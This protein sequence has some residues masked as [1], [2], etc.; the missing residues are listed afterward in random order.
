MGLK[1]NLDIF[2]YGKTLNFSDAYTKIINV[3]GDKKYLT[4]QT[5]TFDDLRLE[6]TLIYE[7]H[8]FVPSVSENSNNFIKQGYEYLKT[9]PEYANAI[10][11]LEEG[12]ML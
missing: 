3:S 12:Q 1:R 10:D 6:N 2:K 5:A 8:I 4:I 7:E 9:L 11:V